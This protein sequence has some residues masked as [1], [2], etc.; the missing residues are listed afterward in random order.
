MAAHAGKLTS[1]AIKSAKHGDRPVRLFDGGGLYLELMPNGSRLK[2][3]RPAT[4]LSRQND[5]DYR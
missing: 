4:D 5:K 3:T 2:H 1:V